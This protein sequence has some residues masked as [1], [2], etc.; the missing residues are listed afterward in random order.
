M[1]SDKCCQEG[2]ASAVFSGN[3]PESRAGTAKNF[4]FSQKIWYYDTKRTCR[5][6]FCGCHDDFQNGGPACKS[7]ASEKE[8][9]P[10]CRRSCLIS[11]TEEGREKAEQ[12]KEIFEK[13]DEIWWEAFD[14]EELETFYRQL[15]KME[16]SLKGEQTK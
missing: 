15:Q 2:S 9:D 13:G 6:V 16:E 4:E 14:E 3:R 12:V 1:V 11:L 10:S 7:G 5:P 8:I